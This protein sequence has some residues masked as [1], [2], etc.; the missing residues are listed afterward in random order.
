MCIKGKSSNMNDKYN[1]LNIKLNKIN[2]NFDQESQI[3]RNNIFN[4]N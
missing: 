4:G 2:I 3:E 1:T